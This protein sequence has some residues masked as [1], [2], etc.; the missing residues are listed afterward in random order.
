MWKSQE[1]QKNRHTTIQEEL[2]G[3]EEV[4][5]NCP[6]G[7]RVN[8]CAKGNANPQASLVMKVTNDKNMNK[9]R[10]KTVQDADSAV[11]VTESMLTPNGMLC[12]KGGHTFVPMSWACQK[13][14]AASHSTDAEVTSLDTVLR[15]EGLLALRLW[16]AFVDVLEPPARRAVGDL[17]ASS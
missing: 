6:V 5:A 4:A 16:D 2:S 17:F 13:Q 3:S 12:K 8:M 1:D 9:R 7:D 15:M 11:D 10:K 14:T